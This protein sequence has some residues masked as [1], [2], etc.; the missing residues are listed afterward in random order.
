MEIYA[1]AHEWRENEASQQIRVS[2]EI[3]VNSAWNSFN[4][5]ND[6]ALAKFDTPLNLSEYTF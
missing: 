5:H 4:F 3:I 1:G 6:I 2:T